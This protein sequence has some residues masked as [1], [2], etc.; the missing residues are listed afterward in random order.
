M[1]RLYPESKNDA[2]DILCDDDCNEEFKEWFSKQTDE[3]KVD[4]M[5][6]INEDFRLS[7]NVPECNHKL[8]AAVCPKE[9][10]AKPSAGD[11]SMFF[12]C[13]TILQFNNKKLKLKRIDIKK[14]SSECRDF[15]IRMKNEAIKAKRMV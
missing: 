10:D 7:I 12:H 14:V 2:T 15:L 4:E 5:K 8:D 9:L 11:L 6:I 13:Y 3:Q 1:L